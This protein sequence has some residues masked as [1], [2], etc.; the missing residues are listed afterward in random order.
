MP[1]LSLEGLDAELTASLPLQVNVDLRGLDFHGLGQAIGKAAAAA[2]RR[3]Q[4][5][6]GTV[7][8]RRT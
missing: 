7:P 5:S 3:A 1:A 4:V 8:I 2:C 6:R